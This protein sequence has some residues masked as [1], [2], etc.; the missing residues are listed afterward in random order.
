MRGF[1]SI[2]KPLGTISAHL[3]P[4]IRALAQYDTPWS[5]RL[6]DRQFNY[7]NLT[8]LA[9]A[10]EIL[11][12][13]RDWV[14]SRDQRRR[15]V[16]QSIAVVKRL[17]DSSRRDLDA[18][19]GGESPLILAEGYTT[20]RA[21]AVIDALHRTMA[22]HGPAGTTVVAGWPHSWGDKMVPVARGRVLVKWIKQYIKQYSPAKGLPNALSP[23]IWHTVDL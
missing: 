18:L 1:D 23:S 6:L 7:L 21:R 9:V 3:I 8:T 2:S 22:L 12:R 5:K 20:G 19:V 11:E 17:N 13:G 4:V 16:F 15:G 10:L 14:H